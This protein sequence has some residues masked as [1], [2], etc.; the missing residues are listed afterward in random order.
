VTKEITYSISA[1]CRRKRRI[2]GHCHYHKEYKNKNIIN[3]RHHRD[4]S[5]SQGK[6]PIDRTR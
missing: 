1:R 3:V 5:G 4:I 2:T 6:I